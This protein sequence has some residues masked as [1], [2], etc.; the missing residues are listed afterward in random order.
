[1]CVCVC[2]FASTHCCNC[3]CFDG[4]DDTLVKEVKESMAELHQ[5]DK[6]QE[7]ERIR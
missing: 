1:M 4:S 6:E 2:V 3:E 5:I 7:R